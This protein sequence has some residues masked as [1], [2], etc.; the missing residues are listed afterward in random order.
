MTLSPPPISMKFLT[1]IDAR[2]IS[3]ISVISLKH[4]T[5]LDFDSLAGFI[6][7]ILCV[8]LYWLSEDNAGA[9]SVYM[10][11]VV[12]L[13]FTLGHKLCRSTINHWNALTSV[14]R[15]GS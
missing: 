12:D 1:I 9:L 15:D 6:Y 14:K 7:L 10:S 3:Y 4:F 2:V 11:P 8:W 5:K 13:G